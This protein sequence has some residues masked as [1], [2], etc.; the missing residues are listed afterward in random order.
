MTYYKAHRNM[1]ASQ[2]VCVDVHSA[3]SG[4]GEKTLR[5]IELKEECL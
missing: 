2:Y 4:R 3:H 1:A 5:Q